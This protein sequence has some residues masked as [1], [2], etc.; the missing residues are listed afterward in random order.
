MKSYTDISI[1]IE[2]KFNMIISNFSSISDNSN[3]C[4]KIY[5]EMMHAYLHCGI[6]FVQKLSF[7]PSKIHF[8]HIN[9]ILNHTKPYDS[10]G[11]FVCC[12]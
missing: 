3:L 10:V 6:E 12:R 11:C 5:Y 9:F 8:S 2:N 1:H 4:C 7:A